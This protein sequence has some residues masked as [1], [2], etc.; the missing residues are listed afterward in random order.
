[1]IAPELASSSAFFK[2]GGF[3]L[4]VG[5]GKLPVPV[6]LLYSQA[7]FA[8]AAE[9]QFAVIVSDAVVNEVESETSQP[10][11]VIVEFLRHM[12]FVTTPTIGV[13]VATT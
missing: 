10:V 12:T 1:M 9:L 8:Q 6:R 3:E 2:A 4:C 5:A 13:Q 11:V 7:L